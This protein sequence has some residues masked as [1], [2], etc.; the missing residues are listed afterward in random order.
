MTKQSK[1]NLTELQTA[2]LNLGVESITL[3][4]KGLD[5]STEIKIDSISDLGILT[6]INHGAQRKVNDTFNSGKEKHG[7]TVEYYNEIVSD[8]CNGALYERKSGGLS[9]F[10]R[11][12][13][14]YILEKLKEARIPAD[15]LKELKGLKPEIIV[16]EVYKDKDEATQR[17]IFDKLKAKFEK[18]VEAKKVDEE[19]LSSLG[20]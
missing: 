10:D 12:F 5:T 17:G 7:A 16:A 13:R 8:L 4:C 6:L 9:Q 1:Q 11:D 20:L 18:V 14:A 15:R 19:F 2:L 3:Y